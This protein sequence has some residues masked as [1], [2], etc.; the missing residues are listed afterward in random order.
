[1]NFA[2]FVLQTYLSPIRTHQ[3][4][5]KFF[6]GFLIQGLH[7]Q[8]ELCG[9]LQDVSVL[10]EDG[11][12]AGK[13]FIDDATNSDI[14]L[15]RGC[16]A[17]AAFQNSARRAVWS[18]DR[19]P[20]PIIGYV[21]QLP[22]HAVT[23]NHGAGDVGHL[24][25]VVGRP[26]R[27]VVEYHVLRSP[28]AEQYRDLV[29]QLLPGHEIALVGGAL[30]RVAQCSN[31]PGYNGNLVHLVASGKRKCDERMAHFVIGDHLALE[32]IQQAVLFFQPCNDAF[33]GAGEILQFDHVSITP[34]GQKGR[35]VDEV[36]EVG[37]G[38]AGRET[39]DDLGIGILR[40]DDL[41]HVNAQDLRPPGLVR[42][43]Y[44][45]LPVETS[46]TKQGGVQ[47]LRSVGRCEKHE[48]FSTIEAI[49]FREQLVERL[50]PLVMPATWIE[51]ATGPPQGIE[52]INEDDGRSVL[53]RLL[54]EVP[55]PGGAHPY[56]HF[57]EFRA[58][59]RKEGY[60]RLA[61]NRAGKQG[62][63]RSR[64]PHQQNALGQAGA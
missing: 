60:L 30:D 61:G 52:L 58:I 45:Y 34:R 47:D 44:Q 12:R 31:S 26:G 46:G 7:V 51:G 37:A 29:L 20:F 1:R 36:C 43:V 32:G 2:R 8:Q 22:I 16:L 21:P 35:L 24:C 3:F 15:L 11:D 23:G 10:F 6:E 4:F 40:I 33:D 28:P 27:E 41:A 62:L 42:T 57:H 54:E 56:E 55:Y 13:D 18:K 49:Q 38:E 48:T 53:A 9:A 14:D 50:L 39:G 25:Q 19:A 64:G 63:S 5:G 59:D 17:V